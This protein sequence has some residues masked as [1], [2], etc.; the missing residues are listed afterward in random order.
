MGSHASNSCTQTFPKA[1]LHEPT[2]QLP[3]SLP[4]RAILHTWNTW[5]ALWGCPGDSLVLHPGDGSELRGQVQP[6][7]CFV[8]TEMCCL[9]TEDTWGTKRFRITPD[10]GPKVGPIC[11][12]WKTGRAV[13]GQIPLPATLHTTALLQADTGVLQTSAFWG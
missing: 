9:H 6:Y 10:L 1:C 4:I 5:H 12:P 2:T 7:F 11:Q 8:R 3:E 13:M